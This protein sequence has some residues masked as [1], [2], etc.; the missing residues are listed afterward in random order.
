MPDSRLA[1]RVRDRVGRLRSEKVQAVVA[2]DLRRAGVAARRLVWGLR[3]DCSP[4][5]RPLYIVGL[6]RSGTNMLLGAFSA[7]PE[8]EIH[9]ESENSRAFHN[10]GL[11][12]DEV[13]R[14]LILASRHRAIVF[15]PLVDAH[16][17]VHLM[18]ELGTPTPGRSIWIY[19]DVRDRIKSSIAKFHDN[20][21]SVVPRIAAGYRGWETG[22]LSEERIELVHRLGGAGLSPGSAAALFWY[23]RNGL[24]FDLGLDQRD[25]VELVS[26]D[27]FVVD[28]EPVMRRLCAFADVP[29]RAEMIE[30]IARRPAPTPEEPDIE[31]EI[32]SLCAELR[33][34]L[35]A[36]LDRRSSR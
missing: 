10:W 27:R 5:A 30:G 22:G 18:T 15:K 20:T 33:Q 21:G 24:F 34:R 13:V 3:H 1:M 36:E 17:V 6:Q 11:R 4:N 16:R 2:D 23:L 31:P 26:Y 14:K 19:R 29:Y 7:S 8:A 9:N 28:P 35:D 25:D 32:A 12:E